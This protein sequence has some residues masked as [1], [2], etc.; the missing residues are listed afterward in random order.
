MHPSVCLCYSSSF[1]HSLDLKRKRGIEQKTKHGGETSGG[2]ECLPQQTEM[3]APSPWS[4]W[5]HRTKPHQPH[6]PRLIH[7]VILQQGLCCHLPMMKEEGQTV[8]T[9]THTHTQAILTCLSF[10]IK[11]RFETVEEDPDILA[12]TQV[13]EEAPSFKIHRRTFGKCKAAFSSLKD[14]ACYDASLA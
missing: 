12:R 8:H 4:V 10:G 1:S 13:L 3:P 2:L 11:D 6:H 5:K 7:L 9:R 14:G